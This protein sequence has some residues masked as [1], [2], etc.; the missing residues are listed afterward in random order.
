[1]FE[2]SKFND[3]PFLITSDKIITYSEIL[4]V[5]YSL[6]NEIHANSIVLLLSDNSLEIYTIY[7]ALMNL[8]VIIILEDQNLPTK[9]ISFFYLPYLFKYFF[10]R[11]FFL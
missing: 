9:Q 10:Q 3:R 2:I 4:D 11:N 5:S 8:E 1:M 7:M 6:R